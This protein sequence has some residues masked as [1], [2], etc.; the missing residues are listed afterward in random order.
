MID[1]AGWNLARARQTLKNAMAEPGGRR[2]ALLG[3]LAA[4]AWIAGFAF[5]FM[6]RDLAERVQVQAARFSNLSAASRAYLAL[7]PSR[8]GTAENRQAGDPLALASETI[9]KLQLRDR[10]KNLSTSGQGVSLSL[11]G[12]GRRET[13][14][15]ARE[16]DRT[17]L[18]VVSAEIRALPVGGKR[19]LS[20]NLLLGAKP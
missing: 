15:L 16:L 6:G 4:L 9:E 7:P 8:P 20:V 17:R 2:L 19:L 1:E 12:L 10:L 5:L 14:D 18:T 13:L 3:G 11:E